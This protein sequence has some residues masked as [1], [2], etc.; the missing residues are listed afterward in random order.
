LTTAHAVPSPSLNGGLTSITNIDLVNGIII[1]C[2]FTLLFKA[3]Y[4]TMIRNKNLQNHYFFWIMHIFHWKETKR[5]V[6]LQIKKIPCFIQP[7]I[8]ISPFNKV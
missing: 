2:G 3:E 8:A 7:K 5:S 4:G 6:L 1:L